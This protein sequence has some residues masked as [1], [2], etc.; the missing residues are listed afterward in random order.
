MAARF[1]DRSLTHMGEKITSPKNPHSIPDA[2]YESLA[3]LNDLRDCLVS[4]MAPSRN[5]WKEPPLFFF[6]NQREAQRLASCPVQRRDPF[7]AVSARINLELPLLCRSVEVRRVARTIDRLQSASQ[8]LAPLCAA[9]KNLAELLAVPDDETILAIHLETRTGFRLLVRGIVDVGQFHILMT[10]AL[11]ADPKCGISDMQAIPDRFLAANQNDG[12]AIPAGIPMTMETRFQL[13]APA[14]IQPD[15]TLRKGFG[16]CDHWLWPATPLAA[17]PQVKGER[18]ILLGRPVYR[19][20]WDTNLRFQGMPAVLRIVEVM[21]PFR[22]AEQLS[23]LTGKT[24]EP[25]SPVEEDRE[26]LRAA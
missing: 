8:E 17:I 23:L 13:Y 20:T 5:R 22:V 6:D 16:G 12:T 9:A 26:L 3:R 1:L 25:F 24:I 18:M 10:A 7:A 14:A 21:N 4:N 11:F 2:G 19:A 15:G